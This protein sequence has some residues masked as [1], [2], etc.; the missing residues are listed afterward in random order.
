MK[1]TTAISRWIGGALQLAFPILACAASQQLNVPIVTQD[2]SEWCWAADANAVL[3]YRGVST[4]QCSIVNWVSGID[5]AC[6]NSDFDWDDSSAN[7]PNYMTGTT[8]ISGI[9]WSLGRR[10]ST[11]YDEP[12]AYQT[13][14]SAIDQGNPVVI[15]WQWPNGG[16]HFLVLDGYDDDGQMI[17][18]MNPWPGEGAGYGDYDWMSNG[19]GNMGTHSWAESLITD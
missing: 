12:A 13:V 6:G 19:T 5:Y 10:D 4:T 8:G 7:A 9:L 17:Y 18:F 1:T 16:G 3:T 15:L 14:T 2:H 11:Y